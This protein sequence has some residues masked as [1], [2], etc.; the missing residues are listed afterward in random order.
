MNST[1]LKGESMALF[2]KEIIWLLLA[3]FLLAGFAPAYASA[4]SD[5]GANS[6]SASTTAELD[7]RMPAVISGRS[8]CL[9]RADGTTESVFLN[10]V[11]LGTAA[12]GSFPGEFA[13]SKETYM[14]WFGYIAEMNVQVIRVYVNQM[15]AFYEA[16][17]EYNATAKTP[18]YLFHGVYANEDMIEEYGSAYGGS[19]AFREL[20]L[21][22]IRNAVDMIHGRAE[23]EKKPGNAGGSYTADVSPWVIGWI[24]GIE[25]SADFVLGTNEAEPEK[26]SFEG[27]YVRTENASPFEVFLAEAAEAA[28]A[29]DTELYGTQR[30]V[31]LCNWCTTDPLDH[32]NEPSPEMEDAVSVDAEHICAAEAF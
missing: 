32:P 27:S 4:A 30:P 6:A 28:I 25:W 17:A 15:P 18:L 7:S 26:L 12:A 5:D 31:A 29:R 10:G 24:L 13:I 20:F 19:G 3:C 2:H 8:F 11:N 1:I 22:D 21:S 9:N 23:V 14:R 16:L